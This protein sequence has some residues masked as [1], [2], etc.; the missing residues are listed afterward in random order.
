[1]QQNSMYIPLMDTTDVHKGSLI[2]VNSRYLPVTDLQEHQAIQKMVRM[3]WT[4]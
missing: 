1:M 4:S 3:K 2:E